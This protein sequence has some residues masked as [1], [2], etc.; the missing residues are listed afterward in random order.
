MTGTDV[1][2]RVQ[3]LLIDTS[4]TRWTTAQLIRWI[5]DGQREIHKAR[6]DSV[7]TTEVVVVDAPTDATELSQTLDTRDSFLS[8]LVDFVAYRCFSVDSEDV[9]NMQRA[10]FHRNRFQEGLAS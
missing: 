1:K 9:A 6:P 10:G 2:S 3:D 7:Y 8:A 5:N 4:G